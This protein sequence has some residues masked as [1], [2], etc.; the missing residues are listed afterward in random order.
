VAGILAHARL[1]YLLLNVA[2]A[3]VMV[4]LTALMNTT[5][6]IVFAIAVVFNVSFLVFA[7]VSVWCCAPIPTLPR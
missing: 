1:G 7:L 3:I 2:T 4:A 6:L 5:G